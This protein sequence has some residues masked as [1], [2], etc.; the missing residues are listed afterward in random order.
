MISE[1][2][3]RS[4]N[5]C[6][7]DKI[8]VPD[9]GGD[10]IFEQFD[11][12]RSYYSSSQDGGYTYAVFTLYADSFSA[13]T[14][15]KAV[16]RLYEE[17]SSLRTSFYEDGTQQIVPYDKFKVPEVRLYDLPEGQ[18]KKAFCDRV[19]EENSE[20]MMSGFELFRAAAVLYGNGS[21]DVFIYISGMIS[22]GKSFALL[23]SRLD[24]LYSGEDI[25]NRKFTYKDYVSCYR[26]LRNDESYKKGIE[27]WKEHFSEIPDPPQLP[28]DVSIGQP[29]ASVEEKL[30]IR[31]EQLDRIREVCSSRNISESDLLFA[32]YCKTIARYSCSGEFVINIPVELR[33]SFHPEAETLIG[34]CS[35]YLLY[36]Y[37]DDPSETIADT[38]VRLRRETAEIAERGFVFGNDIL[39]LINPSYDGMFTAPVVFTDLTSFEMPELKNFTISDSFTHTSDVVLDTVLFKE[40]DQL[41]LKFDSAEGIF[42]GNSFEG[43]VGSFRRTIENGRFEELRSCLLTADDEEILRRFNDTDEDIAYVPYSE[44]II[45][46]VNENRESVA[47]YT[48]NDELTY[49][50][51][52]SEV[53]GICN[54]FAS[55]GLRQE[56]IAVILG[57]GLDLYKTA[58]A[59]VLSGNVYVPLD[60]DYPTET[61]NK[62]LSDLEA[63]YIITDETGKEKIAGEYQFIDI[64]SAVPDDNLNFVSAGEED[65]FAIIH[66]SGSTGFPK[67]AELTHG[68]MMNTLE[69]SIKEFGLSEDDCVLALTNHCHDMSLFDIFCFFPI[70]GAVA[71][72]GQENWRDP[73]MWESMI[74]RCQVTVWN[75]VPSLMCA[76]LETLGDDAEDVIYDLRIII[77]GGEVI[78][79]NE[80]AKIIEYNPDIEFLSL[81]GPTETTIWSIFHRAS[82]EDL[83][84]G[85]IPYGKPISNMRYYLKNDRMQD[86]PVGTD[87]TMYVSGKGTVKGYI[88]GRESERFIFCDNGGMLYNTGDVGYLDKDVGIIFVGRN[89][90]Q[91]K[92]FGKRIELDGIENAAMRCEGV[93]RTKTVYN[94]ERSELTT[95]YTADRDISPAEL[96]SFMLDQIPDYMMPQFIIRIDEMPLTHNGKINKKKLLE[97]AASHDRTGNRNAAEAT[98]ELKEIIDIC[99][100]ILGREAAVSGDDDFFMIG[101]TSLEAMKFSAKVNKAYGSSLNL[102]LMFKHPT[103]SGILDDIKRTAGKTQPV[104]KKKELGKDEKIPLTPLQQI[105]LLSELMN[106]KIDKLMLTAYI[107]IDGEIDTVRMKNAVYKAFTSNPVLSFCFDIDSSGRAF[108]KLPESVLQPDDVFS[109]VMCEEPEKA[110]RKAY[111]WRSSAKD[112]RL[113]RFLL[114]KPLE[115]SGPSYLA[116]AVHHLVSDEVTITKLFTDVISAYEGKDNVLGGDPCIFTEYAVSKNDP[117]AEDGSIYIK[118][119]FSDGGIADVYDFGGDRS[120]DDGRT[121]VFE[122][123]GDDVKRYGQLC[124][125]RGV[126]LQNGLLAVYVAALKKISGRDDIGII[127]PVNERDNDRD[128]AGNFID[129]LYVYSRTPGDMMFSEL[130][131]NVSE[132]FIGAYTAGADALRS[133]L[134]AHPSEEKKFRKNRMDY[135]YFNAAGSDDAHL[136]SELLKVSDIVYE[137][138]EDSAETSLMLMVFDTGSSFV[139]RLGYKRRYVSDEKADELIKAIREIISQ[140][141]QGNDFSISA[142]GESIRPAGISAETEQRTAAVRTSDETDYYDT[143]RE[144]WEETLE[145]DDIEDD[146]NFF[147]AGGFSY[148]LYRLSSVI[149]GKLGVKVPFIA[150]MEY[151]T[152]LSLSEYIS[153]HIQEFETLE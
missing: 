104:K 27:Y 49:G 150:L 62:C 90:N 143:V 54:I 79:M 123:G 36:G 32:V 4:V 110:A 145:T 64:S 66:T 119:L 44:K 141:S 136:S 22:D 96:K 47:L 128:C 82:P 80:Y 29:G 78:P 147:D 105:M 59:V 50:R 84:R 7:L 91:I 5:G 103:L 61:L 117:H 23:L 116:V 46:A 139:F 107:R 6:L 135:P 65:I 52:F 3:R 122:I 14:F 87:G 134:A 146:V 101:G 149:N 1:L 83:E 16:S 13:D 43:I 77:H 129:E 20:S 89:D 33:H 57:K 94:K 2:D 38:A 41:L 131:K 125:T 42:R 75:S 60:Y 95:F 11:L 31:G 142:S 25:Q 144:S 92:R 58:L 93:L 37:K 48:E 28:L 98:G 26:A 99:N 137:E 17:N 19:R 97:M 40:K 120:A 81:G 114:A 153:D 118:K 12:Q 88:G 39:S 109:A 63:V 76:L 69:Y 121:T 151:P 56:R 8:S 15:K 21:A 53:N 35:D 73:Y 126:T 10:E 130:M 70:G 106:A 45:N 30:Y 113:I 18:D 111:E 100:E 133:A 34:E 86:V 74:T 115:G 102:K 148:L 138:T 108:Q 51:F 67:G 71:A 140:A 68:G 72:V 9:I 152:I 24:A 55:K 124:K 112:G 127:I 132:S 85:I